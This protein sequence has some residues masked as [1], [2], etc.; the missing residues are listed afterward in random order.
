MSGASKRTNGRASGPVLRS[1]FLAVLDHS[2]ACDISSFDFPILVAFTL[3]RQ[4]G[5][6]VSTTVA[7]RTIIA[8]LTVEIWPSL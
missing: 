3:F 6:S 2:A 1:V 4:I 8:L 7:V 5:R